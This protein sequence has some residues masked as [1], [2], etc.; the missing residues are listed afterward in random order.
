MTKKKQW[1]K[2]YDENDFQSTIFCHLPYKPAKRTIPQGYRHW[3]N[4][5]M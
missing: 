5:S 3:A 4:I 2:D 1:I